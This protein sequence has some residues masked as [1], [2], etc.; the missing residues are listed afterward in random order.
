MMSSV[1]L[2]AKSDS[3][4]FFMPYFGVSGHLP[5]GDMAQRF[6]WDAMVSAGIQ[7]KTKTNYLL[8]ISYNYLFGTNVKI[9]EELFSNIK[10]DQGFIIDN[11]GSYGFV[12][13]F[14][15]GEF[16]A[17]QLGKIFPIDTKNANA[18][19][20]FSLNPGFLMHHIRIRVEDNNIPALN[21]DYRK[22]YDRLSAGL[23]ISEQFGYFHIDEERNIAN[24][25]IAIEMLQAWTKPKRKVNF[26]TMKPDKVQNRLDLLF[27][28]KIGWM[29]PIRRN[30]LKDY[31]YH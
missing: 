11:S 3:L 14:E 21:G 19:L 22:G 5:G 20:Y 29:L 31:Y 25:F 27:G 23:G 7:Y 24:Y 1:L 12:S 26:D 8:G 10:T 28:I 18:G 2:S 6:G 17:L 4:H 16:Y 13:I 15:S 9:E 30:E